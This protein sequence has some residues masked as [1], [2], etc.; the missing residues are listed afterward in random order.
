ML[1]SVWLLASALALLVKRVRPPKAPLTLTTKFWVTFELEP[2][3]IPT[4]LMVKMRAGLVTMPKEVDDPGLKTTPFTSVLAESETE[5]RSDTLKVAVS[6]AP[7]GTVPA[8]QF[9]AAFQSPLAGNWV[10]V[11]LPAWL[12][13]TPSS[14][15]H[16]ER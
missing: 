6:A 14:T 3:V 12:P 11:P 5:V 10:Q 9:P 2:F 13:R 7:L 16:A 15:I 4:P 8:L 1:K